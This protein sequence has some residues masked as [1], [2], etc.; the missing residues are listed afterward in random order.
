[1]TSFVNII[2]SQEPHDRQLAAEGR[3]L[4]GPEVPD[5]PQRELE[6]QAAVVL[7]VQVGRL[8]VVR[9]QAEPLVA[10]EVQQDEAQR[11]EPPL[12]VVESVEGPVLQQNIQTRYLYKLYTRISVLCL[13]QMYS[14]IKFILI[15]IA[16]SISK[17][18][19]SK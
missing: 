3:A 19:V 16:E 9:L 17:C 14:I 8:L 10:A 11:A 13:K 18:R 15:G 7:G 6:G 5:V 1:L 2:H 4:T 12:A